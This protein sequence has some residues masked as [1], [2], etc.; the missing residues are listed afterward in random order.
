ML[1]ELNRLAYAIWSFLFFINPN[2]SARMQA[3]RDQDIAEMEGTPDLHSDAVGK[4][5]GT[6]MQHRIYEYDDMPPMVLKVSTP[7]PLLRFPT[8]QEAQADVDLIARFFE[9]Y[10]VAPVQVIALPNSRYVIKQRRLECYRPVSQ[11]ELNDPKLQNQF[12]E[13]VRRN[14]KMIREV[15][16]SL[17]F[18]G[19]EGQR[20][21]RAAL[22][23]LSATPTIANLVVETQRDGSEQLRVID[24]DLENFHPD[25][26]LWRDRQSALAARTAFAINRFL[27]KR[28]FR[29]DIS[30]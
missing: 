19:R 13:I 23:G 8:F 29:V 16:R 9:V 6:G 10:A 25:A 22:I 4:L 18:L 15:G 11:K 26:K 30:A 17:D 21:C 3:W 14:Q 20:K 1:A 5:I 12:Q 27:I 2:D 7:I 24:T 28:F